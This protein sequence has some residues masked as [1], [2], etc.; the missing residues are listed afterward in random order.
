VAS[1]KFDFTNL[2]AERVPAGLAA[3]PGD[4]P[5]YD[6]GTGFPDPNSFPTEGLH[7]ALG[8]ALKDHGRDLV[9]YPHMQG[10]PELRELVAEKLR[11][12][13][14]MRID[15]D[16]VVLTGGSGPAIA[17]FTELFTNPGDTLLTEY[18]TYLGALNIMQGLGANVVG[19]PTDE[20]GMRP[21]ALDQTIQDLVGQGKQPKFIYTI[22][23]FQNPLG[24]DMKIQRRLD[25]LAVAQRHGVPI[26]E[27]DAYEDLRFE[28]ERYPAIHSYDESGVMLYSGSF[29]KIV[30]PGMRMGY[31]VA[32]QEL[33]PRINALHWGRPTSQFSAL[34][35]L[36]YLRDHLDEHVAELCDIY[37]SRRDTMLGALGESLGSAAVATRPSGGMYIWVRLPEGAN[38]VAVAEKARERGAAYLPGPRFSPREDGHNYFRLCFGYEDHQGIRDGI[39]LLGEV[40]EEE[41]LLG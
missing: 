22:P 36:Y 10:L 23:S 38:T 33:I 15:P 30:A 11:R 13:R 5:R 24:T 18:Y 32:P 19:V 31:M 21:D 3:R 6:F 39:A 35:V 2:I 1:N 14:G 37:R 12:E 26:Y 4:R 8:R 27:D 7:E 9:L 41:G 40:F 20:E 28:G 25:I 34:A 17:M 16:Q 29:S